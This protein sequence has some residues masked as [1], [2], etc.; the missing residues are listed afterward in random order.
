MHYSKELVNDTRGFKRR[1]MQNVHLS[2]AGKLS[3]V[4]SIL[5][6]IN[7]LSKKLHVCHQNSY[8]IQINFTETPTF[9]QVMMTF[10]WRLFEYN[11]MKSLIFCGWLRTARLDSLHIWSVDFYKSS[12]FNQKLLV[13]WSNFRNDVLQPQR[14]HM[15]E[16]LTSDSIT[17]TESLG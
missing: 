9:I 3:T 13:T 12:D 4:W 2:L 1:Q 8:K 7:I 5:E 6:N 17:A 15:S 14:R 11:N 16:T 10:N